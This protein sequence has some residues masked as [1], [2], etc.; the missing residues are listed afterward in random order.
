MVALEH[1]GCLLQESE[2][3]LVSLSLRWHRGWRGA[4]GA[5]VG[6]ERA[7]G[8]GTYYGKYHGKYCAFS[9]G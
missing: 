1:I 4:E 9:V 3:T 5:Q 2:D 8:V 7:E 6:R